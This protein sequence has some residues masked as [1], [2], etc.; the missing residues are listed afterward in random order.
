M[1]ALRAFLVGTAK[2]EGPFLL[3]WVCWQRM[4]GFT[5]IV[6]V[7][8]DCTDHSPALPLPAVPLGT[9]R[10]AGSLLLVGPA[11]GRRLD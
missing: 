10:G 5:D 8:N 1:P 7:T 2:N 4:L 3:E 6:I 9:G 11:V